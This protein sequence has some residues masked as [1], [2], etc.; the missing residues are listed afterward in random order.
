MPSSAFGW[1]EFHA[2]RLQTSGC[3]A[4]VPC[5]PQH[6]PQHPPLHTHGYFQRHAPE[7]VLISEPCRLALHKATRGSGNV[8][9]QLLQLLACSTTLGQCSLQLRVHNR[10][11]VL[12]SVQWEKACVRGVQTAASTMEVKEARSEN[13]MQH[14]WYVQ[15]NQPAIMI[16]QAAN[17]A[18]GHG[19]HPWTVCEFVAKEGL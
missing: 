3:I 5:P 15:S 7:H 11:V 14:M 9:Y 13:T 4:P 18:C 2:C 12:T 10:T 1:V 8:K 19:D 16:V 6:S 17:F